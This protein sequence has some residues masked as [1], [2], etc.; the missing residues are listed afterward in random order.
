MFLVARA[1][2]LKNCPPVLVHE[3]DIDENIDSHSHRFDHLFW[4]DVALQNHSLNPRGFEN[5][6]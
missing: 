1:R 4:C 6:I 5:G 3:L 2:E